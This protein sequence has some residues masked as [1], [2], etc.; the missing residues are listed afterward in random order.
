MKVS[1]LIPCYNEEKTIR[2]CV[3]SALNQTR[4]IDEII[5]VDDSSTDGSDRVLKSFKKKIKVVKTPVGGRGKSYAQEFGWEHVTGDV[6]FMTDA[7]TL[8]AEDFVE[9]MIKR[10]EDPEVDAV[11]GYVKSLKY[12]WITACRELDYAFGQDLHKSAQDK[13]GSIVVIPGC[14]AAFRAKVF[15]KLIT[16]DHDT[17]AE[18]LDFTYKF[19][20]AGKKIVF[21]KGAVVYTQDPPDLVSYIKQMRRWVGGGWQC[22]IK[23]RQ[24][25]VKKPGH[26]LEISL[27]YIEGLFFGVWF[28]V[29]PLIDIVF[30][31]E[32][33][34]GFFISVMLIGIYGAFRRRRYDLILYAP[35]FPFLLLL[36]SYIFFEQFIQQVVLGKKTL[37]W[38]KPER[39]A[40]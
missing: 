18:D 3:E 4:R 33:F 17:L 24:L 28:I 27:T 16:F 11:S 38:Y 34:A 7:D 21:E 10:F 29:L 37:T 23:H 22:V 14:G 15:K 40:I 9:K 6:V 12:N 5:V 26:A 36:N 2:R 31:G 30:F 35:L 13:I 8:L 39:R 25:L 32:I 19:H 20:A 1:L